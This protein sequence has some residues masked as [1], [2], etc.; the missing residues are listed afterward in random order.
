MI[1][2]SALLRIDNLCKSFGGLRVTN[3]VSFDVGYR[4][5]ICVIGPNGAGKTTLFNLLT[6]HISP[7]KGKIIFKGENLVKGNLFP[8]HI[9]RRKI[10]RSFQKINIF[11]RLSLMENVQL[12][13]LCGR[14]QSLNF[15][16]PMRNMVKE[17]SLQILD[18]V[19]LSE[20]RNE[21]SGNLAHG[22]QKRLELAIAIANQPELLFLDEP[23]AGMSPEET[24]ETME[25][26][27][28]IFKAKG[29]SIIV[30]EHD[31]EVVF[32]LSERI[33]VLHQGEIIADGTPEEIRNNAEV[34]NVYFGEKRGA[35]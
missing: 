31:M 1:S 2:E 3:N 27:D 19:G 28:Q 25:L 10:G 11:S 23:T 7:D 9:C 4:E 30:V 35:T 26:I 14:E 33:I 24:N 21:M 22:D 32:G 29:I 12:A 6:R 16:K 15:F 5:L 17:E 13:I 20:M 34:Q 8:Y 18:E